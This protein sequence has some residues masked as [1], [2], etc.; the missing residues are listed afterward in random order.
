MWPHI[1][2]LPKVFLYLPLKV[3]YM[4]TRMLSKQLFL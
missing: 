3:R 1:Y 4:Y 2:Y